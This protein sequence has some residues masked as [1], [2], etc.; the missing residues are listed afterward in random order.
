MDRATAPVTA[1]VEALP[2][3]KPV[4]TVLYNCKRCM[5]G[6]RVEYPIKGYGVGFHYRRDA[7]GV[8]IGAGVW[9]ERSGGGKPTVYGGDPLGV[10]SGCNRMMVYGTLI[11]S[12]RADV[13]CDVR[14]TG[15]RG[16]ICDC[17]CAGKNHGSAWSQLGAP[18]QTVL[19][20]A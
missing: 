2:A 7:T 1:P 4:S 16:F 17:S 14:C 5:T 12:F 11:G 3:D 13:K 19:A 18:L 8:L 9:I 20:A 15:A 10:C 6:L